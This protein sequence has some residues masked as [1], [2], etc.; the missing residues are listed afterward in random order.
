MSENQE[1]AGPAFGCPVC[2]DTTI[3]LWLVNTVSEYVLRW[4]EDGDPAETSDED[5]RNS[6]VDG[7]SCSNG[8]RFDE[9]VR[10]VAA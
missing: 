4:D 1:Q 3:K 5:L 10:V 6:D 9:P 7:Y 2:G 8:H